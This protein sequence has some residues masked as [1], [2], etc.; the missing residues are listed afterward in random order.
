MHI[1]RFTKVCLMVL[2]LLL[3]VIAFRQLLSPVQVEAAR[4]YR[5]L[6]EQAYPNGPTVQGDLDK[7]AA[8][9][10]EFVAIINKDG[11]GEYLLFRK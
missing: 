4:K 6:Y 5:Y 2:V 1:D 3:A 8:E 9:G 11:A 7:R 10:W